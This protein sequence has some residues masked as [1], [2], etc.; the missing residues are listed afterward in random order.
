MRADKPGSTM[1]QPCQAG[2]F[3]VNCDHVRRGG[4]ANGGDED[5]SQCDACPVGYSQDQNASAACISCAAGRFENNNGKCI[6]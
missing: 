4:T 6:M 2:Q 5:V 3:G 1:C